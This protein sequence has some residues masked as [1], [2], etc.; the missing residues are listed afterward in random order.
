MLNGSF[1][2]KVPKVLICCRLPNVDVDV[3][4]RG[5]DLRCHINWTKIVACSELKKNPQR[6]LYS[7]DDYEEP[8]GD[9]SP[10][11]CSGQC[12]KS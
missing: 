7:R 9:P 11:P 1:H 2:V 4:R 5:I 12:S 6:F 10:I 3:Y 8:S